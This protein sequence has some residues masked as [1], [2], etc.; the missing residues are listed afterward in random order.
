ML[1][2]RYGTNVKRVNREAVK[3]CVIG[4]KKQEE[5]E[6]EGVLP[7]G[8]ASP[9]CVTWAISSFSCCCHGERWW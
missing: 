2:E 4:R 1:R 3:I 9:S 5:E 6:E 8:K 7:A